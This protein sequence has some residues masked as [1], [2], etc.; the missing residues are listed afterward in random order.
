MCNRVGMVLK[1]KLPV[2]AY[3]TSDTHGT[4]REVLA[5]KTEE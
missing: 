5:N 3:A 2:T 1:L 4:D